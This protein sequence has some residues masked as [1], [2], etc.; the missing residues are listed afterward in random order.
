[1]STA[2]TKQ[3]LEEIE[4]QLANLVDRA[5][6]VVSVAHRVV[7]TKVPVTQR[8]AGCCHRFVACTGIGIREHKRSA[9]DRISRIAVAH[10]GVS[11]HF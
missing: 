5:R 2:D 1:M 7:A 11:L 3:R 4:K 9:T 6:R 10:V 8:H